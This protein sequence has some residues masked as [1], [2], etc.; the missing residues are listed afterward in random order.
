MPDK[1]GRLEEY[2][3]RGMIVAELED[4][5]EV[6]KMLRKPRATSTFPI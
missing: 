5:D 1:D 2:A 6:D 3:R 4:R